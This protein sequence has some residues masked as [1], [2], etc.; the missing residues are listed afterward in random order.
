MKP[1]RFQYVDPGTVAEAVALLK[2]HGFDAK[3][4]AGGQSL[5]PLLNMRLA[6]PAVVV[7]INQIPELAEIKVEG[8]T[9]V[10]GAMVRQHRLEEESIIRETVPLLAEVAEHIGHIQIRHRGTVGGSLVH[11][12][13]AAELP[14]AALVL[15]VEFVVEGPAEQRTIPVSEFFYGYLTTAVAPDELLVA[16]RIPI[17]EPG[18]GWGFQE[19]ARRH[20]DFAMAGA[21][22]LV[23]LDEAG[24][25]RWAKVAVTGVAG[26]ALRVEAMESALAGQVPTPELLAEVSKLAAEVVETEDMH[27][28]LAYRQTAVATMAERALTL[29]VNRAA[30]GGR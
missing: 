14:A 8:N 12:D 9:L 4:L 20:G 10:L 11:A 22:T 23:N 15:D 3:I 25:V 5:M 7:D 21:A 26:A 13:P 2:E 19:V 29:A 6:R 24:R 18:T 16:I 1:P 17:P 30:G 28:T 27:A